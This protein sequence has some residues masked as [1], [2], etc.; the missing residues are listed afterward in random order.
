MEVSTVNKR[1]F[2]AALVGALVLAT[3]CTTTG[4]DSGDPATRRQNIDSG[5]D[6]ALATLFR[7]DPGAQ[8]L[9]GRARGVLVFPSVLEAGFIVG[10][11]RGDGALRKGGKTVSYHRTTGG[12][13]GLQAGAQSTA[14]FLLF[15]TDDAL[16]RF[17]ASRGWTA[18]VDA[19][20]TLITVG[21]NA[22]VTTAT[23]QQPIIGYVL[24]NQGIMAGV[25]IDGS[26]IT[27]LQL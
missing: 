24:S 3:G 18:G 13:F 14:V 15:M 20:V 27:R 10:G 17:E 7:Q 5:V 11:W 26:R 6:S 8:E 22:Q 2:I 1:H 12:S 16:A 23:S 21:A 25:T 19:T 4:P 9:V